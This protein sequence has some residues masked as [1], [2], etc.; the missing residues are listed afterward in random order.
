MLEVPAHSEPLDCI[1]C[2]C[3]FLENAENM[4]KKEKEAFNEI[5]GEFIAIK[6]EL[7]LYVD[8]GLLRL[9]ETMEKAIDKLNRL[10]G[11]L[12][13]A[14]LLQ[15]AEAIPLNPPDLPEV[16]PKAEPSQAGVDPEEGYEAPLVTTVL[17]HRAAPRASGILKSMRRDAAPEIIDLSRLNLHSLESFFPSE[18][19]KKGE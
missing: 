13:A 8:D 5:V 10:L 6:Y 19:T 4:D 7:S 1:L 12:D 15:E 9:G 18:Q 11:S 3:G 17:G 16:A 14:P 2:F